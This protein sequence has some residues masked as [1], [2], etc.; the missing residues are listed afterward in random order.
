MTYSEKLRDPRWQKKRLEILNRAGFACEDCGSTTKTLEVHHLH[1]IKGCEPWDYD[2]PH[3]SCYCS[4][5]HEERQKIEKAGKM[6]FD[7]LMKFTPLRELKS[8]V[9]EIEKELYRC[10]DVA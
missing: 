4:D 6:M 3:L 7:L 1:Y 8:L 2:W 9:R 5:C 10:P